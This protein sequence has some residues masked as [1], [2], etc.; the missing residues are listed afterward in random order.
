[1]GDAIFAAT[2]KVYSTVSGRRFMSDLRD[3]H[4][5]GYIG[6]LPSYNSIFNILD[7]KATS[8][9]LQW[10]VS[11]S[12]LPLRALETTFAAD[13]SGFS[14]SRFD[15]WYDHKFGDHRI[16][17]AW[18]KAHIMCGVKTNVITSVE[19]HSQNAW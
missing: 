13:S 8:N 6:R 7:S 11:E 12:A 5:K 17:R 14:G 15:R 10:L 19:I 1:M 9:I 4:D 16:K 2:Y 18:V 3:A